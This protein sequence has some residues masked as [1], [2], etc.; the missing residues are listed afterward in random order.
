MLCLWLLAHRHLRNDSAF[1]LYSFVETRVL[2]WIDIVDAA[3]EH[4]D[5]ARRKRSLMRSGVD[6]ARKPGDDHKTGMPKTSG[7]L[8]G[9]FASESGGVACA[10]HSNHFARQ[11]I[12]ITEH[13]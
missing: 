8:R 7:E 6:A 13:R 4:G 9:K 11:H 1:L 3:G 2:R 5:R 12:A 10:H